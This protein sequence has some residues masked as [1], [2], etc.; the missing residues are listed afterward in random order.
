ME[1]KLPLPLKVPADV[2]RWVIDQAGKRRMPVG[3]Y[4]LE[5]LRRGIVD[6]TIEQTVRRAGAAF[7]SDATARE[8]LRQTLIVRFQQEALLRGDSHD[9]AIAAAL[10]R[11]EDELITLSVREE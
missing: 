9:G 2:R 7:S 8:L 3:T 5:L 6:E 1:P 11:A 10:R 4:V